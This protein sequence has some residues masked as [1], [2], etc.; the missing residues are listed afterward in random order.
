MSTEKQIK[1][2]VIRY[3]SELK[4]EIRECL[5]N[6][7]RVYDEMYYNKYTQTK[8]SDIVDNDIRILSVIVLVADIQAR[9]FSNESDEYSI[10]Y[11]SIYQNAI[12]E[13]YKKA[14]NKDKQ[15]VYRLFD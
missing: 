6:N 2:R 1:S 7:E 8:V 4:K 15:T 14:T 9:I 12:D 5:K 3:K 11:R 10:V 13:I